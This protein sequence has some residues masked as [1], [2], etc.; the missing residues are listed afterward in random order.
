M[1]DLYNALNSYTDEG[2]GALAKEG[3]T[4]DYDLS[5]HNQQVFYNPE[6]KKMIYNVRGTHNLDDVKTDVA[7]ALGRLQDTNRYKEARTTLQKAKE[8]YAPA[9][10]HIT[11]TSLGGTIAQ[12]IPDK[13]DKVYTYNK[14]VAIGA[15][16]RSNEKAYRTS[17]DLVSLMGWGQKHM[18]TLPNRNYLRNV[19]TNHFT[20]NIKNKGIKIE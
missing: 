13:T 10:T 5:N 16:T 14:G 2:R 20:S 9:E 19:L 3:Y 17:G 8:K 4:Y 1:V 18:I 6:L 7:L 11:G 15:K 12:Y